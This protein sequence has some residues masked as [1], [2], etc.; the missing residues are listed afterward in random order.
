MKQ[1]GRRQSTAYC[2]CTLAFRPIMQARSSPW[3]CG[4]PK[5]TWGTVGIGNRCLKPFLCTCAQENEPHGFAREFSWLKATPAMCDRSCIKKRLKGA[6][7][8]ATRICALQR[9]LVIAGR[10]VCRCDTSGV[11]TG[12]YA[13]SIAGSSVLDREL[14]DAGASC[15]FARVPF[16][17]I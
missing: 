2:A 17:I 10:L 16:R 13:Y 8:M 9:H 14:T 15:L 7:V 12:I 3:K 11:V 6:P 4:W 5:A 1:T